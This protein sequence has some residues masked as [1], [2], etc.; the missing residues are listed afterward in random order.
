MVEFE[1]RSH[2]KLFLYR[3]FFYIITSIGFMSINNGVGMVARLEAKILYTANRSQLDY[4]RIKSQL[5]FEPPTGFLWDFSDIQLKI[6]HFS[7][8]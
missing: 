8:S 5:W 4:R 2:Q 7:S 6:V 1:I 3:I